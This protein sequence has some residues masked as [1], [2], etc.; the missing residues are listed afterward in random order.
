M[1]P[2]ERAF[3]ASGRLEGRVAIVTGSG[4]GIGEGIARRLSAEGCPVLIADVNAESAGRVAASLREAGGDAIGIVVNVTDAV[5]VDAMV[6]AA[7]ERW[8]RLDVLVN[9][10]GIIRA[11]FI[12]EMTEADWDAVLAVNLKGAFLCCRAAARVMAE[13]RSGSIVTIS[14]KSGKKGGQWLSA[15]CASKFGVIGLTQSIA[16]DLAAFGVRVNA[17]C[18]GNVFATPMWDELYEA[19]AVKLGIPVERVRD[20]YTEKVPLGRE[21]HMEDIANVVVFLASE[22]ASY[23]TGQAINVTGGQEMG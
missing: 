3:R 10:A 4:Q 11:K 21:C 22:E 8:G 18:P 23:M 7:M 17:V 15:Y 20:H 1:M 12:T 6:A 13:Q 16:M 5:S 2:I 9:N 19:Y 14:S